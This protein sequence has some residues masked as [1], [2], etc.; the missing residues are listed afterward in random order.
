MFV[1]F[2][3]SKVTC[4]NSSRL[5]DCTTLPSIQ[6]GKP[7]RI[8]DQSVVVRNHEKTWPRAPRGSL[9]FNFNDY[10]HERAAS[11][12]KGQAAPLCHVSTPA[13]SRPGWTRFP[14]GF[15]CRRFDDLALARI[16]NMA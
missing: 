9:R 1:T 3:L 16:C 5:V 10:C 15:L 13:A 11:L 7:L 6:G 14:F 12:V 8:H 2:L 4:S